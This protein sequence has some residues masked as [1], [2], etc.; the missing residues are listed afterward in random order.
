MVIMMISLLGQIGDDYADDQPQDMVIVLTM[1]VN[2]LGQPDYNYDDQPQEI[3][4]M[5]LTKQSLLGQHE[6]DL[7]FR[8]DSECF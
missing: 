5:L 8:N 3:V 4:T 7:Q 2:P 6:D 1:I